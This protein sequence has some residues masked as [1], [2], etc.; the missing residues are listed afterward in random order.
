[1]EIKLIVFL[2]TLAFL[3]CASAIRD[4]SFTFRVPAAW[5]ECFYEEF[6]NQE[7]ARMELFYEVISGGNLDIKVSMFSPVD[8]AVVQPEVKKK[9][10]FNRINTEEDGKYKLCLDN[11]FSRLSDKVVYVNLVIYEH[12]DTANKQTNLN[13]SIENVSS[14]LLR[15]FSRIGSYLTNVTMEQRRLRSREA[16][17]WATALSNGQR[18]FVWSAVETVA[19]VTVFFGQVM[20]IRS[21]FRSGSRSDGIRT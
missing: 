19:L 2:S 4:T 21:L 16:R 10:W 14:N 17:H 8:L 1:M 9:G 20:I 18:V 12:V 3:N 13:H 15:Q 11:T 5:Y 6:N 7:D